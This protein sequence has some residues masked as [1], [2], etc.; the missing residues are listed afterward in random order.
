[1]GY[2]Q[3]MLNC[4]QLFYIVNGRAPSYIKDLCVSTGYVESRS[5]LRSTTSHNL[6]EVASV[7]KFG[8]RAFRV[9][10]P[11]AWNDLPTDIKSCNSIVTFKSKLKSFLFSRSYAS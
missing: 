11:K 8:E 6:V 10:G 4:S 2:L 9:A 1:M 5:R 7:T 3:A